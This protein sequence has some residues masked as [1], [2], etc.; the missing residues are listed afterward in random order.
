MRRSLVRRSLVVLLVAI[1]FPPGAAAAPV[2]VLGHHGR[3]TWRND[4]YVSGPAITPA[5]DLEQ[6]PV[7]RSRAKAGVVGDLARRPGQATQGRTPP[8]VTVAGELTRLQRARQITPSIRQL[9]TNAYAA[10]LAA[11]RRLE[12]TRLTE[13]SAV[14]S[15]IHGFAAAHTLTASRLPALFAML[16]ANV[17]WWTTGPLLNPGQRVEFAGS[18]L[19]WQY[20]PGQG[21]QL[22]V[23]GSFGKADGLYTAGPADYPAMEQLLSE[24]IPLAASRGGGLAWE[25]YFT[26]DGGSPPWTSAMAQAT[27][28]EALARAAHATGN[29]SY[30][31]VGDQALGIFTHAPP[32]GV[33]EA[34]ANGMRF[35]QYSFA[36]KTDIIN[37]YLQTLIGLD[38]FARASGSPLAWSLFAAGQ[39]QAQTEVAS[40]NTGAWSLY[41]PGVEDDLSYHELV[42]GF[43]QGMCQRTRVAVYC[44][45]AREFQADLKTPPTLALLTDRAP[46]HQPISLRFELSKVSHVGVVITRGT[47]TVFQTSAQFPHGVGAF[48]IPAQARSGN[49][50]VRLRATD[51]AGNAAAITAT[52]QI[53][54]APKRRAP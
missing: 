42:I 27:G 33:A 23:L 20:Y 12:G 16:A 45:T 14:T 34:A 39:A 49:E 13:L 52:L 3:A 19:V 6:Y 36:P 26:F 43:L 37:A 35:L 4:P 46:A 53:M 15:L 40:F 21:I 32:V 30:L 38:D 41:Q 51:L 18:E 29:R 47:T 11:E 10:A 8:S 22:Q 50:V 44:T 5:P 48:W 17:K 1:A 2:L 25:Y 28:L 24:I 31:Q 54:P 7:S 9:D